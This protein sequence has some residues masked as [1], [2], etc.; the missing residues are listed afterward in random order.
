MTSQSQINLTRQTL[1]RAA[2]YKPRVRLAQPFH[3]PKGVTVSFGDCSA[4][5]VGSEGHHVTLNPVQ[6]HLPAAGT[7]QYKHHAYNIQDMSRAFHT[8]WSQYWMRDTYQEQFDDTPWQQLIDDLDNTIPAQPMLTIQHNNPQCLRA[9]IHRLKSHKAVGVDGW[10][11]EELQCLTDTM[12]SDLSSLLTSAWSSGLTAQLMQARTLLFAKRDCPTSIS[13]GGPITILGYI[14]RITSKLISDQVL[15]QW[16]TPWPPTISGGLPHRSARDLC[17]MQ[18]LQIE[19]AKTHH[20]AW[21]GWTMDLV[22]AFNLIPRRVVRHIFVLLGIPTFISDFW[23]K[24]LSRLTRVLQSIHH[25]PPR[26]GQH[27]SSGYASP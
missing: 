14:A 24:S 5:V 12:I 3:I 21:G 10:H 17:I 1:C 15:A 11:A 6:G 18:Q 26:R 27:V 25:R 20:T 22:K 2:F 16:A 7:L 4:E 19:H 9:S 13:D 8:Y 23:F